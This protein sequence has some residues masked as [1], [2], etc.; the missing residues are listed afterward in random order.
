MSRNRSVLWFSEVDKEDVPLVGKK[1]AELG[2]MSHAGIPIPN[3]F[4]ISSQAYF[5]FM[6]ENNL[7]LAIKQ[8]LSTV[9]Y[10]RPDSLHQVSFHIKKLIKE[11]DLSPE[12]VTEIN[13]AYRKLGA[14]LRDAVVTVQSSIILSEA[15]AG[16]QKTFSHV[17]GEANLILK[18]REIWA[19]L[20]DP[21]A[22]LYRYQHHF[23]NFREGTAVTVQRMIAIERSGM[24]FTIHPKTQDKSCMVIEA[25]YGLPELLVHKKVIPDYFEVRKSDLATAQKIINKQDFMLKEHGEKIKEIPISAKD[26][27][28]PKLTHDEVLELAKIG[29]KLEHQSYFPQQVEW[30]IE[31]KKIYILHS[32]TMTPLHNQPLNPPKSNPAPKESSAFL[33]GV[34]SSP[35]IK[36]GPVKIIHN[37]HELQKVTSGDVLVTSQTNPEYLPAMKKAIAIVTEKDGKTSHAAMIARELGIPA[38]VGVENAVK[39]LKPNNIITVNGTQGEIYKGGLLGTLKANKPAPEKI[40]TKTATKLY[41]DIG[42]STIAEQVA[43]EDMDGIGLLRAEFMLTDIGVHP[44]QVIKEGKKT[45]YINR[46]AQHLEVFCK[47]FH[48]H[49]VIYRPSDFKSNEYKKLIG[50]D[51]FESDEPNPTLGYRGAFRFVNDADVFELELE[52]IKVVRNK[53]GLKNLWMMLPFVRTVKELMEIKRIISAAGLYRSPTFK[54]WIMVETPANVIL[55]DKFIEVGID[56]VSIDLNDV[57]MLITGVDKDSNEVS[58]AFDEQNEAVLWALQQTIKTSHAHNITSSIFGEALSLYPELLEKVIH[59]GITSITTTPDILNDMRQSIA[60]AEHTILD[61]DKKLILNIDKNYY[62][63]N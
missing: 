22:I 15:F 39:I 2:E 34:P 11:G 19:S 5:H 33:T 32:Q 25:L 23:E 63:K 10:E 44:K 18:I 57:T 45:M 52:A 54:L 1:G 59:W 48:P 4:L 13:T 62:G 36:T 30:A 26:A 55:L 58:R 21:H 29:K 50:G 37:T 3:G 31:K 61:I 9:N 14:I 20:F 60:K 53:K 7:S 46:L 12:F 47:A 17:H 28:K 49:P 40:K 27:I 8:L 56:G 35:G 24:I 38:V 16:P 51:D 42:Q 41:V 43:K 6:K